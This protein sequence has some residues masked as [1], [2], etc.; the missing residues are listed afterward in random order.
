[1]IDFPQTK[2]INDRPG[3]LPQGDTCCLHGC[4]DDDTISSL[5]YNQGDI[6]RI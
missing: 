4:F 2:Q 6:L 1:M 5:K 3:N